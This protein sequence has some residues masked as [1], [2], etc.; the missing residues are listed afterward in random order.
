MLTRSH[1][2]SKGCKTCIWGEGRNSA[3]SCPEADNGSCALKRLAEEA[4]LADAELTH[5]RYREFLLHSAFQPIYSL[6][7]ER[8]VGYEALIRGQREGLAVSPWEIFSTV[9]GFEQTV[10]L[11]RL[12]RTIHIRNFQRHIRD[13]VW[14]FLNINPKVVIGGHYFGSFFNEL[15]HSTGIP[16]QRIVV[17]IL[18]NAIQDEQL[19][20]QTVEYYRNM[21]CLIAL[22]DFGSGHSNFDRILR[23]QPDIVKLDTQMIRQAGSNRVA[24]RIMP[25]LVAMLHEAGCLVLME[26]VETE[27]EAL[28]ALDA[29]V[30][31]VQGFYFARPS[32]PKK[33]PCHKE[34]FL[35][36]NQRYRQQFNE[37][38]RAQ[39]QTLKRYKQQ[40][41]Q[42]AAF[43][44]SGIDL[45]IA[46]RRLLEMESVQRCYVLD[47]NGHQLGE[48][49]Y[50]VSRQVPLNPLFLPLSDTRGANWN[51]KPYFRN[52]IVQPGAVKV[53]RPYLSITGVEL[54]ITLSICIEVDETMQVLCCD[55]SYRDEA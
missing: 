23:I 28:I 19:L 37:V 3:P 11:D 25:N 52:A 38:S 4:A 13:N 22:D 41:A 30:D 5:A 26:G 12:C 32:E 9:D 14:L 42:S 16:P 48:N 44:A 55:I 49:L 35:L 6:S 29:N 21:G 31:F 7:H 2:Q 15:L 20:A 1:S 10:Y 46:C 53:T 40:F 17:E 39:R 54:C 33:L 34:T 27:D 36:L 43:Y 24:R 8:V 45:H 50:P 18:E 51:R 47:R